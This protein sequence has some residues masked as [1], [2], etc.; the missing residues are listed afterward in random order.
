MQ[1]II[2]EQDAYYRLAYS[3]MRNEHDAMDAM[4]DMI[5][6]LYQKVEEPISLASPSD[7][8]INIGNEKLWIRSITKNATDYFI[9]KREIYPFKLVVLLFPNHRILTIRSAFP[10]VSHHYFCRLIVL[11]A[12][13]L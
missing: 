7:Q 11:G 12:F 4:E 5:V 1:L 13:L 8:S 2:A 10:S 9:V 6:A 3:Y